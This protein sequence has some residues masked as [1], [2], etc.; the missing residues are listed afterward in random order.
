MTREEAIEEIARCL[1]ELVEQEKE[2]PS[3]RS[4]RKMLIS[5]AENALWWW[6]QGGEQ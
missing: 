3:D 1:G 2:A 5:D 6:E 4:G